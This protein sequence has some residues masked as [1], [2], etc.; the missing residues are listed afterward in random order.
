MDHIE[1]IVLPARRKYTVA[2]SDYAET[3]ARV[4]FTQAQS[5]VDIFEAIWPKIIEIYE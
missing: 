1:L 3:H 5:L 2:C 4:S